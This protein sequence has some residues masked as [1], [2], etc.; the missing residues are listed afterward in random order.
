[1][2]DSLFGD[3]MSEQNKREFWANWMAME[4]SLSEAK[5]VTPK[6]EWEDLRCYVEKSAYA[7]LETK[8]AECVA[9]LEQIRDTPGLGG[10]DFTSKKKWRES[11]MA[12]IDKIAREV[13]ARVKK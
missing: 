13:L 8:L 3:V 4:S 5:D 12:I 2:A 1:M 10:L 6:A 9:A 11:S 7:A